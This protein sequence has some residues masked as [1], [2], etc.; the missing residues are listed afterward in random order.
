MPTGGITYTV[1]ENDYLVSNT[2]RRFF[3]GDSESVCVLSD[4]DFNE[5]QDYL[6]SAVKEEGKQLFQILKLSSHSHYGKTIQ[7][8]NYVGLIELPVSHHRI[9]IL[10]KIYEKNNEI[11]NRN[12]IKAILLAM[13]SSLKDFPALNLNSA[14]VDLHKLNLYEIFIRIFLG[15][16]LELTKMGLRSDYNVLCENS[17]AFRGRLDVASQAKYNA[18]HAERFFVIH[19]EYSLSRPENR[20]IKSAIIKLLKTTEDQENAF[21]ARRLLVLFDSV[22]ESLDYEADYRRI[23]FDNSNQGY[24]GIVQWAMVFLRNRSFSIFGGGN[25][26]QSLLFPMDRIFERYIASQIAR[27][28]KQHNKKYGTCY[29]FVGQDSKKYLFD[30][31]KSF[32]IRPDIKIDGEDNIILDTK[33]KILS[34]KK[35]RNNVSQGDMYQMY[36]YSK[37]YKAP[38]VYLLYPKSLSSDLIKDVEFEARDLP[39]PT[40]VSLRFLDLGNVVDHS[41]DLVLTKENS[42]YSFLM[43]FLSTESGKGKTIAAI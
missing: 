16:V 2:G 41:K 32:K 21:L 1:R 4:S 35:P 28:I 40:H 27:L 38:I 24:L 10:P 23:V 14:S 43:G 25:N 17:R 11:V 26:G 20:V 31:P 18:F 5:L 37:R 34:D 42:L 33:W 3:S 22:D 13:L 36:A 39:L 6:L 19:D 9:E 15:R 7:L 8:K 12:R 29:R 30:I